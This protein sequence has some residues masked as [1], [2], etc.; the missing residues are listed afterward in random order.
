M[1]RPQRF[2]EVAGLLGMCALVLATISTTLGIIV[3]LDPP[4]S[5]YANALMN[6][7]RASHLRQD[8]ALH[9][10][11][12]V[13]AAMFLAQVVLRRPVLTP[14]SWAM[15][16]SSDRYIPL[17]LFSI[18]LLIMTVWVGSGILENIGRLQKSTDHTSD[19]LINIGSSLGTLS[20]TTSI[21]SG[22]WFTK[23][24]QQAGKPWDTPEATP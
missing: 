6:V 19:G 12:I 2:L 15:A 23:W 22:I 5:K 14:R 10:A 17:A 11:F 16:L 8:V 13:L 7:D 21:V 20:L 9:S 3:A 4:I 24:W 1:K 18:L